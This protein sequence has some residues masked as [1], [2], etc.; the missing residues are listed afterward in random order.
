MEQGMALT[1]S[2]VLQKQWLQNEELGV[3]SGNS[4]WQVV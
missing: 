4:F 1:A 2:G 3:S